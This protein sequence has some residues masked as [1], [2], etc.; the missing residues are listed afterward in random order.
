MSC[1]HCKY[2]VANTN[3]STSANLTEEDK[4]FR[5]TMIVQSLEMIVTN[6]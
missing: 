2:L 6:L 5:C 1:I 3:I 4:M